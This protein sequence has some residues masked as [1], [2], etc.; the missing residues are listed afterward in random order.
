[1]S[2]KFGVLGEETECLLPED[3]VY[4][5]NSFAI[6]IDSINMEWGFGLLYKIGRG[7]AINLCGFVS[8]VENW[9]G[10]KILQIY[11]IEGEIL[12]REAVQGKCLLLIVIV[13]ELMRVHCK[14]VRGYISSLGIGRKFVRVTDM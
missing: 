9:W 2:G 1:M 6:M 11:F 3:E 12:N 8:V 4:R 10:G 5:S 14:N 13:G 7:L